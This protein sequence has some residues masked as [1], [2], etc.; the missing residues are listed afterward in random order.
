MPIISLARFSELLTSANLLPP[1]T[2]HDYKLGLHLIISPT[3]LGTVSSSQDQPL[4]FRHFVDALAFTAFYYQPTSNSSGDVDTSGPPPPDSSPECIADKLGMSLQFVAERVAEITTSTPCSSPSS[5]DFATPRSQFPS[6]SPNQASRIDVLIS[7][8]AEKWFTP[9]PPSSNASHIQSANMPQKSNMGSIPFERTVAE[10]CENEAGL[11]AGHVSSLGDNL[12][13]QTDHVCEDEKGN[14]ESLVEPKPVAAD[15]VQDFVPNKGASA[16]ISPHPIAAPEIT[17]PRGEQENVAA[18][19]G[20]QN[21]VFPVP[22]LESSSLANDAR[23]IDCCEGSYRDRESNKSPASAVLR[24]DGNL[25]LLQSGEDS[26]VPRPKQS[27]ELD[28]Q[29]IEVELNEEP[30][31][32]DEVRV[33]MTVGDRN[34]HMT[35]G[36]IPLMYAMSN[37]ILPLS[38]KDESRHLAVSGHSAVDEVDKQLK[39]N[40]EEDTLVKVVNLSD[41]SSRKSSKSSPSRC[42]AVIELSPVPTPKRYTSAPASNRASLSCE[43]GSVT[44]PDSD[45]GLS[46]AASALSPRILLSPPEEFQS[47]EISTQETVHRPYLLSSGGDDQSSRKL[48][49][50]SDSE[51]DENTSEGTSLY[52][53][54]EQRTVSVAAIT[55]LGQEIEESSS[56]EDLDA[57]EENVFIPLPERNAAEQRDL[58]TR[59]NDSVETCPFDTDFLESPENAVNAC[60]IGH[61]SHTVRSSLSCQMNGVPVALNC[62]THVSDKPLLHSLPLQKDEE[63]GHDMFGLQGESD[64]ELLYEGG[65]ESDDSDLSMGTRETLGQIIEEHFS[66]RKNSRNAHEATS[67]AAPEDHVEVPVKGSIAASFIREHSVDFEDDRQLNVGTAATTDSRQACSTQVNGPETP[68]YDQNVHGSPFGEFDMTSGQYSPAG[69]DGMEHNTTVTEKENLWSSSS[70][71]DFDG[72][73]IGDE[74]TGDK[75]DAFVAMNP[76]GSASVALGASNELEKNESMQAE[77]SLIPNRPWMSATKVDEKMG[78]HRKFMVEQRVVNAENGYDVEKYAHLSPT[79]ISVNDTFS[80]ELTPEGFNVIKKQK[81]TMSLRPMMSDSTIGSSTSSRQ[82]SAPKQKH[83]VPEEGNESAEEK[84]VVIHERDVREVEM[85]AA[86]RENLEL[87]RMLRNDVLRQRRRTGRGICDWILFGT[88]MFLALVVFVE[89]RIQPLLYSNVLV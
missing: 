7:P 31:D 88:I 23:D 39:A 47:P 8:L 3:E 42:H 35:L 51:S 17:L 21:E 65:N 69:E 46:T 32:V 2:S 30:S 12:R 4:Q 26:C 77:K 41:V 49:F 45:T 85:V 22:D 1:L 6:S 18:A 66:S 83:H 14:C 82:M 81:Q 89:W 43:A 25:L 28:D 13:K 76:E 70:S 86:L 53:T 63:L 56:F 68:L 27:V 87:C 72:A 19:T 34:A 48:C 58:S 15:C 16:E 67:H 71:T 29:M 80:S 11:D 54:D 57:I 10:L 37:E 24:T 73:I 74:V 78:W 50:S 62:Q 61:H 9:R 84:R 75:Q 20:K 60:E 55:Q 40:R 33:K 36:E 5:A 79:G 52:E 38:E 64:T 44:A 59:D